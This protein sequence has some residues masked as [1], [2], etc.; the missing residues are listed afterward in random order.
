MLFSQSS[1]KFL[2]ALD[3][4]KTVPLSLVGPVSALIH[5]RFYDCKDNVVIAGQFKAGQGANP[6]IGSVG[7][8]EYVEEDR[9]EVVVNDNGQK[10]ELKDVVKE[11]KKVTYRL[12]F[13]FVFL[14]HR[15]IVQVHPYEE[16][17]YFIQSVV[18]G[19][20]INY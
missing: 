14:S 1:P 12:S 15:D 5:Y 17:A 13:V 19:D 8:V 4:T 10:A 11:L 20:N 9:V 18:L 16:T 3:N 6:A 2:V 7:V